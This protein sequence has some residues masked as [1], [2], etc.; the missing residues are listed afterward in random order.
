MRLTPFPLARLGDELL[1]VDLEC[2]SPHTYTLLGI[3]SY[4]NA[5]HGL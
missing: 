3:L 5:D 1:I 4:L 2:V